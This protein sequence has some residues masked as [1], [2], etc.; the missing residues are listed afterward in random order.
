MHIVPP[1]T[2]PAFIKASGLGDNG[3]VDV[4]LGTLQHK[5]YSNIWS[6]GDSANLPAAKTAAAIFS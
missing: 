6:L 2:P 3:F 1:N 4:D 5:K